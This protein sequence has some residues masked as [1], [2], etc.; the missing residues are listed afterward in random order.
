MNATIGDRLSFANPTAVNHCYQVGYSI[1]FLLGFPG[2]LASLFTFSRASL[3]KLSTACLFIALAIFD[4]LYLVMCIFDYLEFGFSVSFYGRLS[5]SGFCRFR[6]FVMYAAQFASAW[7][8]V[9]VS[10]DRW[11]RTRFPFKSNVIC[12]PAKGLIAVGVVLIIDVALHFHLLTQWFG[13]LVPGLAIAAC[14]PSFTQ[15]SY[16]IFY[17]MF[18]SIIQII[19]TCIIPAVIMFFIVID[20]LINVHVR[21]QAFVRPIH[22]FAVCR[23]AQQRRS[24][25]R[26]M[27]ILTIGSVC[28]FFLTALPVSIYKIISPRDSNLINNYLSIISI[29]TGLGWIQSLFYAVNFYVHC[30]CSNFFRREFQLQVKYMVGQKETRVQKIGI[31]CR[32]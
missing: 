29:W 6:Y 17:Y 10:I 22:A 4:T 7:I 18:W 1:L 14:G 32:Q 31:V 3:R 9:I 2:N 28:F 20:I 16:A 27:L 15:Q 24:V 8:L 21:K 12:T 19:T 5:Y 26:Q 23:N 30:L 11:I 25:N 13:M